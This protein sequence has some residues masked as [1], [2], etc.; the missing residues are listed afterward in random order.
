MNADEPHLVCTAAGSLLFKG[1][2][3]PPPS[4]L[5]LH[6][7]PPLGL[8][9]GPWPCN[10]QHLSPFALSGRVDFTSSP[11]SVRQQPGHT[12][13]SSV[14]PGHGWARF[15]GPGEALN[16]SPTQGLVGFQ[17]ALQA[18]VKLPRLAP[19]H[20]VFLRKAVENLR[21]SLEFCIW[22]GLQLQQL[23]A[24]QDLMRMHCIDCKTADFFVG[25]FQLEQLRAS[26]QR[27]Q[28]ILVPRQG[29]TGQSLRFQ[30]GKKM[31]P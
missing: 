9:H 6:V 10:L 17:G 21:R 24:N 5:K 28:A 15:Q 29:L 13:V 25:S 7:T 1:G 4:P 16:P 14:T 30:L 2:C 18:A 8:A 19:R 26:K 27:L 23:Q 31:P 12:A 11:P 22:F 3:P 20:A